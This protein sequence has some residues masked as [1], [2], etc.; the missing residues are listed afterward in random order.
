MSQGFNWS[1]LPSGDVVVD[2]GGGNGHI[3]LAIAQ[4]NPGLRVVVQD[5]EDTIKDSK[6]HWKANLPTHVESQMVDFQV[7]DFHTPQP[8]PNAAVFL[9]RHI[10]H[11]WSDERV[12]N[13]LRHL[14]DAAQPTTKLV[15]IDRIPVSAGRVLDPGEDTIPGS[16]RPSA[17]APLL[18]NWGVARPSVYYLDVTMHCMLGGVERTLEHFV[19]VFAKGGWKLVHVYH[20]EGSVNSHIVGV[21]AD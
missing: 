9:L 12:V 10:V 16:T 21:L 13:I 17:P 11:N 15:V 4:K 8:V 5:L 3:S 2:V 14:R 20:P 19:E 6:I 18:P 1:G 7:H